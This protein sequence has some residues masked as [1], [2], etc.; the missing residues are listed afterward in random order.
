MS[1]IPIGDARE[2]TRALVRIDSRNPLLV[3]GGPGE[4]AIAS[5]IHDLFA[6]HRS[7]LGLDRVGE[8]W[9]RMGMRLAQATKTLPV[10]K[11]THLPRP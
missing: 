6:L 9:K 7:R 11:R 5:A 8:F 10:F 3:P 1:P 2:L 4:G